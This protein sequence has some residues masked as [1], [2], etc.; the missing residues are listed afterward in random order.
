MWNT[1]LVR[2]FRQSVWLM[3]VLILASC[4]GG[5]STA[6]GGDGSG[7]PVVLATI[8]SY[9]DAARAIG[10]DVIEAE[11]LIPPA[12]SPHEYD[13]SPRD[14]AKFAHAKIYIKNGMGLDDRFDKMLEGN[15][16]KI[17]TVSQEI[18]QDIILKTA[19][20]P[21]DPGQTTA[22]VEATINPHIWLDPMVQKIA[23]EKIR[24]ALIEIDPADKA[25]FEANAKAYLDQ[26]DQLD[27]DFKEATSHFATK[28]FIGFHSAYEYLAK[29]YGLTQIASIEELPGSGISVAQAERI[30]KLIQ[31]H[32][33]KYI[34]ME[35]ALSGQ[36]AA[37][38][39]DRTG[40]QTIILQ[41]LE[42][43]DNLTDTY[44]SLMRSNLQA[45]K[46]ALG[47]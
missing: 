45:L 43:Y 25:K 18:P 4:G 3:L 33:I 47:T 36:S 12:A 14:K 13:P 8:F 46:T 28:E 23:A 29:R 15:S 9:Y 2:L 44:F 40:V 35:T 16:P 1:P 39:K 24:D 5:G 7:K 37:I 26:L 19:E 10:G 6:G 32:H 17:I 41:P 21:L 34:A 11:I 38:I 42:S 31:D 27:K 20:V 22:P 30:I